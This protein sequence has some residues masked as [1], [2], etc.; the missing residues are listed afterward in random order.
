MSVRVDVEFE[1]GRRAMD[2][3]DDIDRIEYHDS[4]HIIMLTRM[5]RQGVS[6]RQYILSTSN[7]RKM[8]IAEESL[9]EE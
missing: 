4:G 3:Y 5:E 2:S 7:I 8:T 9:N 1:S 6:G